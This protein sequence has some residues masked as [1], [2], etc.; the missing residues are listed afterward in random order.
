[1]LTWWGG[2]Q[3]MKDKGKSDSWM[4]SRRGRWR[5]VRRAIGIRE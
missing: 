2:W 5:K 4:M 1:M 3:G